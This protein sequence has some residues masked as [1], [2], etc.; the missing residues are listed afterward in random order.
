MSRSMLP[1]RRPAAAGA[2]PGRSAARPLGRS[3]YSD[4]AL[5]MGIGA[6]LWL[7]GVIGV[8][9]AVRHYRWALR[10]LG[11]APGRRWTS[12]PQPRRPQLTPAGAPSPTG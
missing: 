2:E 8:V 1:R 10:V 11:P 12:P 5:G 3:A 7:A 4:V 6:I 9:K